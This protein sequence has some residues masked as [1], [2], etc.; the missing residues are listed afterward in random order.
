MHFVNTLFFCL[1]LATGFAPFH[2]CD[3]LCR[4][5]RVV[6]DGASVDVDMDGCD[7]INGASGPV[8]TDEVQARLGVLRLPVALG[9]K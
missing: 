6:E 4:S 8:G 5:A 9:N 2:D 3:K 7:R 1:V